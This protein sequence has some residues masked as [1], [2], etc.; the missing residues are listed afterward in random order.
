MTPWPL[1]GRGGFSGGY[2][3]YDDVLGIWGEPAVTGKPVLA[4]LQERKKTLPVL[5]ALDFPD[6]AAGRRT[7]L[8][9]SAG[10][11]AEAAELI[12][13]TGGRTAALAE[14]RRHIDAGEA[15][16]ADASLDAGAAAEPRSVVGF[17]VRRNL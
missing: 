14:A 13:A 10:D 11:P 3:Q 7:A 16:L 17:L 6:P 2:A 9:E 5:C 15:A 1:W 4:D 12:A 8:M